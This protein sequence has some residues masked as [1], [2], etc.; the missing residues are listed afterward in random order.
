MEAHQQRVVVEAAELN[1]KITKLAEFF[2]SKIYAGIDPA[3]QSRL[4]KQ[5][6]IMHDYHDILQER[7]AAF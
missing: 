4:R 1:E 5:H 6:A 7:I 3:E 2:N